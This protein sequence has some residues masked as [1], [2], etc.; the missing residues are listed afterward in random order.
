MVTVVINNRNKFKSSIEYPKLET[1]KN[2][3]SEYF[4]SKIVQTFYVRGLN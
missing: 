2:S 1:G 3:N 4:E